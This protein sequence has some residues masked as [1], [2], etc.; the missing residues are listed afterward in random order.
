MNK[1]IYIILPGHDGQPFEATWEDDTVNIPEW[2]AEP[3]PVTSLSVRAGKMDALDVELQSVSHGYLSPR[4]E[5]GSF[6]NLNDLPDGV[7]EITGTAVDG[8]AIQMTVLPR[9]QKRGFASGRAWMLPIDKATGLI[10]FE[11][12]R[13]GRTFYVTGGAH[14]YTRAMIA[15]EDGISESAATDSYIRASTKW[16]RTP[17]KA[18]EATIGYNAWK[19]VT[20]SNNPYQSNR[21]CFEKGYDYTAITGNGLIHRG[22]S[23]E[24]PLH[25]QVVDS[26]G[27]GPDP[28]FRLPDP[29]F[30]N[31]TPAQSWFA[32]Q[33]LETNHKIAPI[34]PL[35]MILSHIKSV[36]APGAFYMQNAGHK[37]LYRCAGIN[38]S[39]PTPGVEGDWG[40][41]APHD[42]GIYASN[43]TSL[44][45]LET[46]LDQSGWRDG[47]NP[48]SNSTLY[49]HPPSGLA[50]G[51][52]GQ[53]NFSDFVMRRTMISRSSSQT[54]QIRGGGSVEDSFLIDGN[55]IGNSM[56]RSKDDTGAS[57]KGGM[58][59]HLRTHMLALESKLDRAP[60]HPGVP[61]GWVTPPV[62]RSVHDLPPEHPARNP[63]RGA[64]LGAVARD[65]NLAEA[66]VR[67]VVERL[68]AE[69]R[70]DNPQ[71]AASNG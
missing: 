48:E 2:R 6:L 50:H 47:Y 19:G 69:P 16:G 21:L 12:G 3:E 53:Y 17:A 67:R 45:I 64:D 27:T 9:R 61:E 38:P 70:P 10:I 35:D 57:D 65:T 11:P 71:S 22:A 18:L 32:F 20:G 68:L 25:P 43:C 28:L 24:S 55:M 5:G 42:C 56:G 59:S 33:G 23:G 4:D 26:Y 37:T 40:F 8:R 46:F 66:T 44:L 63:L 51:I 31:G 1:P 39:R 36:R 41:P 58:G 60:D 15:A 62:I 34:S 13:N 54:A 29:L 30:Q 7:A 14:G 52:Y 49:P